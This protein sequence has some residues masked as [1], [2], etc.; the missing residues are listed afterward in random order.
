MTPYNLVIN[1]YAK[2]ICSIAVVFDLE[3]YQ[4]IRDLKSVI[5][6]GEED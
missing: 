5:D 1:D 2:K 6:A 3:P 4:V